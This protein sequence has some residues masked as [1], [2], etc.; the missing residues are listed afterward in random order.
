MRISF[1]A[2]FTAIAMT[3]GAIASVPASAYAA[4]A[5]VLYVRAA[6]DI[7]ADSGPGSAEQ[8]FCTIGAAAAVVGAGQT[9]D[10]GAGSYPERV[11]IDRS[12]TP[13]QPIV[14]GGRPRARCP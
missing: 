3:G 10:I 11:T 5:A 2:G 13:G 6:P 4:D 14:F 7:C 12:G 9:V 8:P 1:L